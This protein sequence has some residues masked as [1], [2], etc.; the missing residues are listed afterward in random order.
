MS[1]VSKSGRIGLRARVML[2]GIAVLLV[3]IVGAGGVAGYMAYEQAK[4][5]A[6]ANLTAIAEGTARQV[7]GNIQPAVDIAETAHG[8]P[9]GAVEVHGLSSSTPTGGGVGARAPNGSVIMA[10]RLRGRA[11][12]LHIA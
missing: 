4:Q 11:L 5:D 2:S 8:D 9:H 6:A 10:Y 12:L 7:T 3:G 1:A